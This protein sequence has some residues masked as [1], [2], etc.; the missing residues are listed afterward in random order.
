[1]QEVEQRWEQLPSAAE[2]RETRQKT[3]ITALRACIRATKKRHVLRNF[4]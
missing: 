2:I 3:R 4:Q 1:M